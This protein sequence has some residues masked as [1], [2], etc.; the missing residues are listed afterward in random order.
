[1]IKLNES[2]NNNP[3]LYGMDEE[4]LEDSS[5]DI[6]LY[7]TETFIGTQQSTI[8]NN[9]DYVPAIFVDEDDA[10]RYDQIFTD[11]FRVRA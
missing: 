4:D 10:E 6:R 9:C 2:K 3:S 7:E 1:M 11:L 8:A 5:F